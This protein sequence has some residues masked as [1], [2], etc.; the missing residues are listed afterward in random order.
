MIP[1]ARITPGPAGG[2][3][4]FPYPSGNSNERMENSDHSQG[5]SWKS[6]LGF[7][8]HKRAFKQNSLGLLLFLQGLFPESR[9]PDRNV[10]LPTGR[11]D[12]LNRSLESWLRA[13][14]G[15][16]PG[17]HDVPLLTLRWSLCCSKE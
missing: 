15:A 7:H 12:G 17:T 6:L 5:F 3:A 2:K 11:L 1:W 4:Q 10:L 13:F 8:S 14:W 16:S 9:W